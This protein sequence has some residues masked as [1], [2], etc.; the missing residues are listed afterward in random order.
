MDPSQ[1]GDAFLAARYRLGAELGRGGMGRVLRAWDTVAERAVAVKLLRPSLVADAAAVERFEREVRATA[2]IHHPHTI[3]VL[4]FGVAEGSTPYLVM[5]LAEGI[6]LAD[7]LRRRGPLAAARAVRI[8][9]QIADALEATHAA[10]IIHR[11]LKPANILLTRRD[12]EADFVKVLDFGVARLLT[13]ADGPSSLTGSGI[14]GTPCYASPEQ[15]EG[16]EVGPASDLYSLGVV[17]YESL[18]GAPP[19]EARTP[20]ALLYHH[21]NS[22]PPP[23]AERRPDLPAGLCEL[24][25]ELMAKRPDE[26][27]TGATEVMRRLNAEDLELEPGSPTAPEDPRVAY[28]TTLDVTPGRELPR[29]TDTFAPGERIGHRYLVEKRLG[30]GGMGAVYRVRDTLDDDAVRALKRIHPSASRRAWVGMFKA[31]FQTMARLRHPNLASVH[32]FDAIHGTDAYFFTMDYVEGRDLLRATEGADWQQCVG[33]LVQVCR[34]LSYVHARKIVHLDLKPANILVS[35]EGEVKV[36]DFG[37]A[38]TVGAERREL[39]ATPFYMAPELARGQHAVDRRADLYSLG[40]TAYHVL[41][42]RVP[43]A[44][45]TFAQVLRQ[46]LHAPLAFEDERLPAWLRAL[47]QRLCAKSPADRF[48]TANEVIVAINQA[49]GLDFETETSET[50]E[51]YVTTAEVVGREA[52][53]DDLHAF[54]RERLRGHATGPPGL[55]VCGPGGI[56]KSCLLREVK[57][58]VQLSRGDFIEVDCYQ[59]VSGIGQLAELVRQLVA[60]LEA[61][62]ASDLVERYGDVLSAVLPGLAGPPRPDASTMKPA[63]R[64]SRLVELMLAA[65]RRMAWALHINNLHWAQPATVELFEA[66]LEELDVQAPDVCLPV[67]GTHRDDELSGSPFAPSLERML[68]RGLVRVTHLSGLDREHVARLM[69]SM[70]GIDRVPGSLLETVAAQTDGNPYLVEELMWTVVESGA[71]GSAADGSWTIDE[72]VARAA[73][74]DIANALRGRF[75]RLSPDQQALLAFVATYG[76]PISAERLQ[77]ASEL[78]PATLHEAM[79][80]LQHRR[81]VSLSVD[82]DALFCGLGHD[83]LG[84]LVV[85]ASPPG[86]LRATH[87][88]LAKILEDDFGAEVRH[89]DR[90]TA[91]FDIARHHRAAHDLAAAARWYRSAGE[92]SFAAR[93]IAGLARAAEAAEVC[94]LEAEALGDLLSL[95]CE[96]AYLQGDTERASALARRVMQLSKPSSPAWYRVSRASIG[97]AMTHPSFYSSD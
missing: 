63:R 90:A 40:I 60:R 71:I 48:R 42:R 61:Q 14:I 86:A 2:T 29:A 28:P 10:G 41:C 55:L 39:L 77:H 85:E 35:A 96:S 69:K 59:S 93:E 19:F 66:L 3:E 57:H 20:M 8:A 46:H 74:S 67:L 9:T 13:L 43:F 56:G 51:S 78:A 24:A 89:V 27:P 72:P 76:R 34:A 80:Q 82:D 16:L 1:L 26:R 32:D 95:Y 73:A 68:D 92:E 47:I 4:E 17:L 65:G 33:W 45:E 25:H 7:E 6:S 52:E 87:A 50:R 12:G 91:A 18:C 75:E 15:A 62:G 21:V 79:R 83:R 58:A 30:E 11:D 54:T 70:L 64:T 84:D 22:A 94:G 81:M 37:L 49:S 44:G 53:L 88:R 5:E 36:V 97:V 23:L 38:T 31:E